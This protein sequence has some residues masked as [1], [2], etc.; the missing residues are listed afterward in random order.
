MITKDNFKNVLLSIG[1]T[2]DDEI[3]FSKV[4]DNDTSDEFELHVDFQN[5]KFE[6]PPE[7]N[8]DRNTTLDFHQ[9]ESFVVFECLVRLFDVGYK[10]NNIVL[11]GKNYEGQS[12]GWID[13]LVRDNEKTE[14]LIIECKTSNDGSKGDDEFSKHWKR[15]LQNGDQLFRYFNTFS[16]ARFLCLYT[17]DFV[18]DELKDT[19]HLITLEDNKEYLESNKKL[20]SY[21]A[22]RGK[23]GSTEEFYKVWKDTYHLDYSTNGLIEKDSKPFDIGKKK[24]SIDDLKEIDSVS[25]QKKYNEFAEILRKY[26]VSSKENAFDKLVNLFLAKI[27]DE[28]NNKN[29]LKCLWKGAAYDNYYALQDRLQS[30]Y[31]IGMK[32]F[33]KDDVAYIE[34]SQ[35][36][37]AFK[38][39]KSK[40]DEAKDTIKRYFYTLKYYNNNPFAFLEVHNETLF[41]Q[42]AVILKDVVKMIQDIK[43]K[44]E[45]QNQFLGDLFEGFLDQG[46]KQDEGQFFTPMPIVKFLI[47][48][49]PLDMIIRDSED[50]PKVIDFAC[51][52]GHFLTEYAQQIK[53]F[54]EKYNR[55]DINQYFQNICGIEKEDRLSKVSQVSAF[56]YGLD[57]ISI[58]YQDG[59]AKS[60]EVKEGTYS[61]LV[62]NPPYSVKGFLGTLSQEERGRYELYSDDLN[63]A[64]NNSIETFFVERAKQLLKADGV[65]AIIL[66]S[67]ILSNTN[68][69]SRCREIILKYFDIAA[70]FESGS[71]TFG[72][73]GTNTVTLFLRRRKDE[74]SLS[75]HLM[76]RVEAWFSGNFEDDGAYEDS[77]LLERYCAF[78]KVD[79]DVYRSLLSGCSSSELFD[80]LNEIELFNEYISKFSSDDRNAMK[81]VNDG[82]KRIRDEFKVLCKKPAFKGLSEEV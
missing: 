53:P 29:E 78:Q 54:V 40:S 62:A 1:F 69:Y 48:S 6:Y 57:G 80:S 19:Y 38:F 76:N 39:L 21:E 10:P 59:L 47:S 5:N 71:G 63:I 2:S 31:K 12:L 34:N 52:A 75:S 58:R 4:Y 77:S 22:L 14:Y 3:Y 82:A 17:A 18:D 26:N 67:S 60:D 27:V 72:K 56:M 35:I 30:L 81:G 70:I 25:M 66:P 7:L 44:T 61:V 11:E 46:F 41:N 15:T 36:D 13:I 43:I 73:T 45:T 79:A 24:V 28:T 42:N 74:P 65:A 55:A 32:D 37:E 68:I 8:K 50:I 51:G 49:L 23:Q 20:I 9:N 16:K 33:F 64:S